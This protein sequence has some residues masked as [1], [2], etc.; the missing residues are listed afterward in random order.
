MTWEIRYYT[1]AALSLNVERIWWDVNFNYHGQYSM[2]V[3][4]NMIQA[5]SSPHKDP[6]IEIAEAFKDHM[7]F[8]HFCL[9]HTVRAEEVKKMP[10]H[11]A[12]VARKIPGVIITP[13]MI[14]E[15]LNFLSYSQ[16]K[17]A[18]WVKDGKCPQCGELGKYI[19][20]APTCSKHGV[21]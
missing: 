2:K 6:D 5:L 13:D 19:G 16:D 17:I 14:D 1:L 4:A 11:I 12:A 7:Q 18:Q 9:N 3:M 8:D 21:Y 20:M 15:N 10:K